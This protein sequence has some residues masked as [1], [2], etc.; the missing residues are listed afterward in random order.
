V[1]GAG[2]MAMAIARSL[3]R[4]YR[5]LLADRDAVHLDR[6]TQGM[7]AEGY[8]VHGVPCDVT[9]PDAVAHL[10]DTATRSGP[11][12]CLAH[13][14]GL[15]PSMAD[16]AL[17]LRVDLLGVLLVADAFVELAQPGTAAVFVSSVAAHL[18][19]LPAALIDAIDEPLCADFVDRVE[20][21][22]G[23][24]LTSVLAYQL[25]KF[26]LI[27]ACQRRA[28][29]WGRRGARIVSLS[30]GLITSPQGA[31]ESAAQPA[32][33]GLRDLIPLQRE[34]TLEEIAEVVDFLVSDRA[35]FIS[36]TDVLVDGGLT[37]AVATS[38]PEIR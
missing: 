29:G 15:S 17:I 27:R 38:L 7:S 32:K 33:R 8:D 37:A 28:Q 34:G 6:Q 2:A 31:R 3:G 19:R 22:A 13:V 35:S 36:G 16:P 21:A 12:G 24:E 9:D 5:V 30:P 23:G 1:V 20:Q 14:V 10:A 26:G 11:L 25:S 18:S 4:S